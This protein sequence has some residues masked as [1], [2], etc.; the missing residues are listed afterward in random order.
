MSFRGKFELYPQKRILGTH[1]YSFVLKCT[2][3]FGSE[4]VD[5]MISYEGCPMPFFFRDQTFKAGRSYRFDFDTVN[6]TWYN[7]DFFA[8]IDK[9]GRILKKWELNLKEYAPGE[10]PECHGTKQCKKCHGQG[11]I[12]PP[13]HPE[14]FKQCN[15]CGGTGT[16]HTCDVPVRPYS[17]GGGPTGIGNGFK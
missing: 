7:H 14:Q 6:W 11:F 12:Y 10:C 13:G 4:T 3:F 1:L 8:I 16:C 17:S 9:K 15:S 2:K 5:C